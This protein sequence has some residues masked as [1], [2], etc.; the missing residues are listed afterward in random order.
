MTTPWHPAIRADWL[1]LRRNGA[2]ACVRMFGAPVLLLACCVALGCGDLFAGYGWCLAASALLAVGGAYAIA[3]QRLLDALERWRFGWCGALPV[4]R[5][6]AAATLLLLT[7]AALVA[8]LA[9]VSA[10]LF[11]IAASAPHSRDWPYAVVAI[12]TALVVG[13]AAAAVRVFRRS[14]LARVHHA[15]GIREPLL[16]LAWLNDPRLPHLLDW[17]RRAA[18]VRWRRGG[19]FVTAGIVLAVVPIG[20]PILEVSALVM[21]V[22]AWSWLAVVVRASADAFTAAVRLLVA[23]PWDARSARMIAFR[24]PLI[25]TLCALVFMA[26]GAALLRNYK[27]AL[28]WIV[29]AGAISAWPLVRLAR[30]T[31]REDRPG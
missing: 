7:A 11:G 29:C 19:S 30:A 16:A 2:P 18:L 10:L 9:F 23:V 6:A 1:V 8:S 3:H 5:G 31:R 17:Q 13:A 25:A 14:A 24:Y 22:L 28:A 21:L 20:A 4:A 12:D 27:V 26:I 15:D